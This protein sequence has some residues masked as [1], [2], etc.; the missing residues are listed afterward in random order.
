[1][2]RL[3]PRTLVATLIAVAAI[4]VTAAPFEQTT[5]TPVVAIVLTDGKLLPL[6]A[7]PGDTW[8][9][10][11]WPRFAVDDPQSLTTLPSSASAIPKPWFAPLP[12]LP[13]TWR[14]QAINGRRT[15]I[16]TAAP[17]RWQI[18]TFDTVGLAT[19]Y[20]DPDPA[21]RSFDFNAGIAVSGDIET[22]PVREADESS[23]EW[24]HLV[25]RHAKA[26]V[27]ADR[28]EAKRRGLHVKGRSTVVA[29]KEL[30]A[31]DVSLYRVEVD[32]KHVYQ[33]FEAVV[34]R[35]SDVDGKRLPCPGASVEY[36]GLLEQR[37]RSETVRWVMTSPPTCGDPTEAREVI[38]GLRS[39]LG[40]QLVVEDSADNWQTFVVISPD[41]LAA[42][43]R[44]HPRQS[45]P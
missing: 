2:A 39:S 34:Q 13:S 7:R 43:S 14:L 41:A 10:L 11:A 28:V 18:A 26:F 30:R 27:T 16:H 3:V 38:G 31:A 21:R 25:A 29:T 1:M 20:V 37:G 40:V 15:I 42:T 22:L 19:D 17:T 45:Q 24:A 32:A 23:P 44:R 33:Y 5:G 4:R 8:Q 35:P 6:A 9:P 12:A 36:H